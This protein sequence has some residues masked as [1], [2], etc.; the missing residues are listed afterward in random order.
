MEM[1][2]LT[3]AISSVNGNLTQALDELENL[4]VENGEET[5]RI[6][7]KLREVIAELNAMKE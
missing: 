2:Y 7:E 5:G 1:D 3:K 6:C 4:K